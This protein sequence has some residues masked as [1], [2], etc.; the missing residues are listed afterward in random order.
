MVIDGTVEFVAR[1]NSLFS[2]GDIIAII[3]AVISLVGIIVSTIMINRTMKK[4]NKSNEQFQERWNQKNI[5]A[6]LT[7][8]ARIEWIQAVRNTTSELI[9][10]YFE[11]LN[12]VDA[13]DLLETV[14]KVQGKT[15]LLILYFGH[16]E[17]EISKQKVDLCYT[18]NNDSKN[19]HIVDFLSSLSKK[20]YRYYENVK[21]NKLKSLEAIRDERYDKMQDHV[22]SYEY[23]D[24]TDKYGIVR[25]IA[26][27]ILEQ[28]YEESLDDIDQ[29][30]D[31]L[32]KVSKDINSDLLMLRDIIRTYLKIEWNKAKT[33]V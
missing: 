11:A 22:L 6:S 5:D 20:L 13:A 8:S 15:E 32:V 33:G 18:V 17:K 28:E 12:T 23:E 14:I 25:G 2:T 24:Y 26:V 21:F 10:L 19:S 31:N 30:I 7:A 1:S 9:A 16:E 29:Q 27:P 3:V 4:I